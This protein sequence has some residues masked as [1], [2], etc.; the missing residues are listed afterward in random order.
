MVAPP[1]KP[2]L[3][4]YF[5]QEAF[6]VSIGACALL[7]AKASHQSAQIASI[8][9]SL[10]LITLLG[11]S[12]L[13]HRPTWSQAARQRLKRYDHAAIFLLIGS[14]FTPICLLAL[15]AADGHYLL[16]MVWIFALI[17]MLQSVFWIS[18]PKWLTSTFYVILGWFAL[19]YIADLRTTLGN[20][21]VILLALGGV[22]FTVGAILYSAK[23]PRL[24]PH[25]FGYHELFHIFT[26]IAAALHFIVVYHLIQ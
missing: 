8:V 24:W 13:Y 4:G 9:Y 19:P 5:H 12:A 26:I 1:V 11:I 2:I 21:N 14:T 18:A 10:G 25:V 7:I 20:T 15:P 16:L 17:G 3:R 23:K 22:F 6:Y